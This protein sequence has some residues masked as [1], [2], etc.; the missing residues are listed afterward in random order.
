[1]LDLNYLLLSR[2]IY[3]CTVLNQFKSSLH[4]N[5]QAT[6]R[7]HRSHCLLLTRWTRR[8][9]GALS[10]NTTNKSSICCYLLQVL[11]SHRAQHVQPFADQ[12][13]LVSVYSVDSGSQP[14]L[15]LGTVYEFD[16]NRLWYTR[17]TLKLFEKMWQAAKS[18][19]LIRYPYVS[20][21]N[22]ALLKNNTNAS[23][24]KHY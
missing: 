12:K 1:M 10:T 4:Y 5:E 16:I 20:I 9:P 6:P 23:N 3:L 13:W 8:R 17:K 2:S 22:V 24:F 18:T 14:L 19:P 7:N 21:S 15:S 11:S